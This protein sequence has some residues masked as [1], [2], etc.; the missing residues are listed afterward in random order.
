MSGLSLGDLAEILG[1][2]FQ[3]AMVYFAATIKAE[4][5]GL[6]AH[7]YENFV[8][9]ADAPLFFNRRKND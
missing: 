6:R 3:A 8:S 9:K 7:V 1:L 4:I 5:S 2:F